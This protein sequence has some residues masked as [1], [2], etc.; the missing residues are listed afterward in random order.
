MDLKTAIIRYCNYQE[1]CHFEVKNKL[2][3][4]GAKTTEVH[5]LL[6]EMVELNLLNEERYAF[7]IVRGRFRLKHWGRVKIIQHLKQHKVSEYC[8]KKA[9]KQIDP[10]EYWQVIQKLGNKKWQELRGER[11]KLTKKAKW[12]RF[13]L[14]KGF[15]TS[16]INEVYNE[17]IN[18]FDKKL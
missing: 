18:N 16:L 6:A 3:E 11:S 9:I 4:L 17:I 10:E 12:Y 7:A 8:I 5:Q 14:Q 15:E 1:R 2:Y 13:L